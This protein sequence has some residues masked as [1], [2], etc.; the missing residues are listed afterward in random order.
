MGLRHVGS[1]APDLLMI[2]LL[3]AGWDHEEVTPETRMIWVS[4]GAQVSSPDSLP[5][6][7]TF[8]GNRGY[9]LANAPF[10]RVSVFA[11]RLHR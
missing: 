7:A 11:G 8:A 2:Q 1:M 6:I 10:P 3:D 9:S 4:S 5:R